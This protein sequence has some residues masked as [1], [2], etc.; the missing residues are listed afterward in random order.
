MPGLINNMTSPYSAAEAWLYDAIIAPAVVRFMDQLERGLDTLDK[1]SSVLDV[2]C[3][4][5][6]ILVALANRRPDLTIRGVDLSAEQVG[7]A[8]DRLKK[9]APA[10]PVVQGNAMDLPFEDG[11]F[12][13]V[14]SCASIKHW[15]DQSLG[16][17]E[18]ARVVRPG[19]RLVVVEA[20]RGCLFS[21]AARFVAQ[22]RI[23]ALLKPLFMMGFRTYVAGQSIDLDDARRM[24]ELL[25]L[26]SCD[27]S[28]IPGTPGLVIDGVKANL[29]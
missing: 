25:P 17:A 18:C 8:N 5:G 16:L 28:R 14:Y 9:V 23:P 21:D 22:W 13:A 26:S 7:R 3:G 19:G 29:S 20:D 24:S 6:H 27:V 2:G 15:P 12:D 10:P 11:T 4:G 1:G